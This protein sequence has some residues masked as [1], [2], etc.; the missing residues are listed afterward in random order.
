MSVAIPGRSSCRI[1]AIIPGVQRSGSDDE[2][3]VGP[4]LADAYRYGRE[5]FRWFAAERRRPDAPLQ[6]SG[7]PDSSPRAGDRAAE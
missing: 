2:C 7:S 5:Y 4:P 6:G 1:R 3:T